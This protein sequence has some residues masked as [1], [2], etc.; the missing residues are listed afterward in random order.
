MSTSGS[1]NFTRTRDQLIKAA[2]RKCG[3]LAEGETATAQ[4]IEEGAEALNVLVKYWKSMGINLWC[5]QD[6]AVFPVVGQAQY[7][8][9]ATGDR[10]ASTYLVTTLSADAA[11]SASTVTLTSVTGVATAYNIGIVLNDGT[12]QWTTINGAPSGYVVTL[13]A[14]LTGAASSG[15]IVYIYQT[16]AQRPLRISGGRLRIN[17]ENEVPMKIISRQEYKNIPLKTNEGKPT[18]LY[19]DPQLTNGALSI[20]STFETVSDFI[21]VTAQREIEDFDTLTDE[22]DLP[23][24]WLMPI[25]WNLADQISLEYGIDKVTRDDISQRASDTLQ[26][27]IAFDQEAVSITFIP[28]SDE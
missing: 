23:V 28:D 24:E 12:I 7:N 21:I 25:T 13:T 26:N 4:Q 8:I 22:P 9:G 20:W 10:A 18:Q 17:N 14:S 5:Y 3:I 2:L 6:I 15:N 1:I 16:L 27:V 19:Y 11:A